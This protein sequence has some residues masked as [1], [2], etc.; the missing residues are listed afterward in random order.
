MFGCL[1]AEFVLFHQQS[2]V[3]VARSI[4][5]LCDRMQDLPDYADQFVNMICKILQEYLDTC[6]AAYQG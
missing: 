3:V 4:Q 2:T 1:C 6:H 5:E